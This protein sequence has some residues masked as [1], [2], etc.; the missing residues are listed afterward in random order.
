M[1][2]GL[3][4]IAIATDDLQA[5]IKRFLEDFGIPLAG[6]EV[7][8]TESTSTAFF[9]LPGTRIELVAP[10]D[11]QGP[12]A[13][14]VAKRGPGLHHI[15]FSTDDIEGDIERLRAKGY[16]FTSDAPKPGAHG[17]RV[18]FLHP[19]STGGVLIELAQHPTEPA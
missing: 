6:T 15:C 18:I 9:P 14:S 4:H 3:D 2:T 7:V 19:K 13:A 10:L 17:T 16:R 12:I 8:P 11:G 5:A 1:I